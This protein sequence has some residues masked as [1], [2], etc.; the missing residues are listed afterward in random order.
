MKM[1]KY[2]MSNLPLYEILF[3]ETKNEDL[4]TKEKDEFMKIIKNIDQKGFE[5]SYALIRI[6][7]LENSEDKSTFK[8]P[9]GGKF[10]KDDLNFNLNDLPLQLKQILYKFLVLHIK[11]MKEEISSSSDDE[12]GEDEVL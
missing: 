2:N 5:I 3:K 9:Y 1:N 6:F 12:N 8:I 4:T 7:Q 10:V 11:T